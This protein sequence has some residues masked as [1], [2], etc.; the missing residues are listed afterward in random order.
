MQYH[1]ALW[2][3]GVSLLYK[4]KNKIAL[5]LEWINKVLVYEIC[6]GTL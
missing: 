3:V 4:N 2:L 5:T 1:A 6:S